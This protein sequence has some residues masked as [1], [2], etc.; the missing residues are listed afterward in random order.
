MASCCVA[1]LNPGPTTV[2]ESIFREDFT[3]LCNK[4]IILKN[5]VVLNVKN[6]KKNL[7]F[8][9]RLFIIMLLPTSLFNRR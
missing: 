2:L 9:C 5:K 1:T 7:F 8:C 3:V 6:V 4:I